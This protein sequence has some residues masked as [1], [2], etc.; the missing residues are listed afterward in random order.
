MFLIDTKK[1][2]ILH[3]FMCIFI[4]NIV[5]VYI[6]IGMYICVCVFLYVLGYCI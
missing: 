5:S 4:Y 1:L 2:S 3:M 6:E